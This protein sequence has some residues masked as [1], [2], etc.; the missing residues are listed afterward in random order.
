MTRR[1]VKKKTTETTRDKTK[2]EKC[3]EDSANIS[4]GNVP[5]RLSRNGQGVLKTVSRKD[6]PRDTT[7]RGTAFI[8]L[9]DVVSS[10]HLH[11]QDIMQMTMTSLAFAAQHA[12]TTCLTLHILSICRS[13][14]F[15]RLPRLPHQH[16]HLHR[17]R[18]HFHP[19][20]HPIRPPPARHL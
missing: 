5:E 4:P 12:A 14:A 3:G 13:R 7:E 9:I 8:V 6:T 18:H 15:S 1:K 2:R 10:L 11:L 20:L 19:L 16:P 17:H